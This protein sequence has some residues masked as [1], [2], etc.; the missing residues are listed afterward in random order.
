MRAVA[1]P[2]RLEM[3]STSTACTLAMARASPGR[4]LR[5]R[6]SRR[7][8]AAPRASR[9]SPPPGLAFSSDA[10][11][12]DPTEASAVAGRAGDAAHAARLL[13]VF[14]AREGVVVGAFA[15]LGVDGV[16]D[17][18]GDGDAAPARRFPGASLVQM[19]FD[20]LA[21]DGDIDGKS[22][23]GF[24]RA[25]TDGSMVATVDE[26][27]VDA[28]FRNAGVGVRL[29]EKLAATLRAREIYDVGA[30]VPAARRS[31]FET[32]G[33]GPDAEGAVLMALPADA[34]AEIRAARDPA[35][36]LK[37]NGRGVEA[38]M[39]RAMERAS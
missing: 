28:R 24:A 27:A 30:R 1:A 29:L 22:L 39:L 32:C 13:A 5:A 35:R 21:G 31:F 6:S 9:A 17:G 10:D 36:R 4:D 15:R 26:I 33:F 11:A 3:A 12:I 25:A 23:V 34:A 18:D 2:K 19:G 14:S 20:L 37:R 16:G 38:L 7:A 8:V